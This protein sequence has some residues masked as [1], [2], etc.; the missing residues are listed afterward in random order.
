MKLFFL[1]LAL[2]SFSALTTFSQKPVLKISDDEI[3]IPFGNSV[4]IGSIIDGKN[5]NNHKFLSQSKI[6]G[7]LDYNTAFNN[8]NLD[9]LST[10]TIVFKFSE[11]SCCGAETISLITKSNLGYDFTF[12]YKT[13]DKDN[14]FSS[15]GTS[16]SKSLTSFTFEGASSA[17][18]AIVLFDLEIV[19]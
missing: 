10:E 7:I 4:V 13:I 2:I 16:S 12:K 3:I 5:L 1:T 15:V 19:K 6:T 14:K 17:L 11:I 18:E 8:V 9:N